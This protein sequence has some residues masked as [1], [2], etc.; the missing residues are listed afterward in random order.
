MRER[1]WERVAEMPLA[2]G[3]SIQETER[4][5]DQAGPGWVKL[6]NEQGDRR[7]ECLFLEQLPRNLPFRFPPVDGVADA[8]PVI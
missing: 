1:R 8:A 4:L 2:E 3:N 7:D 5:T 6:D